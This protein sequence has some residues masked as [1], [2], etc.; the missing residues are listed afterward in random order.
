MAYDAMGNYTGYDDEPTYGPVEPAP[1][2][3]DPFG[4]PVFSETEEERRKREEEER[5]RAEK[6]A[7]RADETVAHEQKVT[8]YENGSRTV[9]TKQEIPAGQRV[10]GPVRP[11]G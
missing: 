4:N 6:E 9:E 8:T 10:P 7:K 5:K 11:G 3:Y 2:S 1:N